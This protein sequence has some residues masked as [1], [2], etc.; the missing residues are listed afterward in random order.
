MN[1]YPTEVFSLGSQ[2]AYDPRS[3]QGFSFASV[4]ANFQ[5]W[6]TPNVPPLYM[7]KAL[8]GSFL[9]LSYN[10]VRPQNTVRSGTV[11]SAVEYF[12]LRT[13]YDVF[14]RLGLYFAPSY[15]LAAGRLLVVE[16]GVR[17]KS[18]SN[19]WAF[20]VG[21]DDSFNP[22][23]VRVQ[24]QLTLGGLGSFGRSPFGL[25]PFTPMGLTREPTSV[26]RGY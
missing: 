4:G 3:D 24:V 1:I 11:T 20:D 26:L 25:N 5:P 6:W 19:C 15:D 23:E 9:Q 7:G 2:V 18:P 13:Y 12:A 10:Y 17:I 21:I 14:D 8:T 16:Y 22:S